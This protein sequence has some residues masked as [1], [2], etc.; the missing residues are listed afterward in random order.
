[1]R[2]PGRITALVLLLVLC[3]VWTFAC[4]RKE[5][6][7]A[8]PQQQEEGPEAGESPQETGGQ[9]QETGEGQPQ[10]PAPEEEE[11]LVTLV[12]PAAYESVTTQEEADR[13][14][15]DNGYESVLLE[16]DGSLTVTMR[17]SLYEEMLEEFTA[18]VEKGLQ[19][20]AASEFFPSIR[21]V[22]HNED[23]SVFTVVTASEEVD[24]ALQYASQ[25]LFMYG[26]LYHFYTGNNVQEIRV[27]YVSAASGQVLLEQFSGGLEG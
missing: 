2:K 9:P 10:E 22:E 18:T 8:E 25:E 23:Y 16:E 3:L 7:G 4:G 26:T 13:I 15:A 11:E 6:T 27:V 24:A 17:K 19:E 5:N 12:I 1:M 20:L 21:S 14:C